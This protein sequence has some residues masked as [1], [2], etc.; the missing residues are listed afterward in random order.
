M[1]KI[2]RE[3]AR[4]EYLRDF[5]TQSPELR[6][7]SIEALEIL[8]ESGLVSQGGAAKHELVNGTHTKLEAANEALNQQQELGPLD[9]P[10]DET[11]DAA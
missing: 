2:T 5:L 6:L 10:F 11:P 7:A 3:Y 1:A 8:H 4:R 9:A